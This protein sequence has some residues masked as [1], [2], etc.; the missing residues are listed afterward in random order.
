MY[1]TVFISFFILLL[2]SHTS[3]VSGYDVQDGNDLY[4]I[5]GKVFPPETLIPNSKWTAE[6][7]VVI[8]GGSHIGFLR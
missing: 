4:E 7:K 2:I 3:T 6:T 1:F 8:K 5:E